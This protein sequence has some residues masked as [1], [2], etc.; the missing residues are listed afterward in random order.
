MVYF[1]PCQLAELGFKPYLPLSY[2]FFSLCTVTCSRCLPILDH[3]GGRAN[4]DD[5]KYGGA[6]S[7]LYSL[8]AY[9]E[10]E[11]YWQEDSVLREKVSN[12]KQIFLKLGH[13]NFHES[14]WKWSRREGRERLEVFSA[15]LLPA[16]CLLL[17]WLAVL[18]PNQVT[19]NLEIKET[20]YL[21]RTFS[22]CQQ[23]TKTADSKCLF[24]CTLYIW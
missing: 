10:T 4:E 15:W 7:N 1:H 9:Q 21:A 23:T 11:H 8:Y 19:R 2:A 13:P 3:G 22:P 17:P 18:P 24:L 12:V 5:S 20:C 14:Y 16:A 6:S